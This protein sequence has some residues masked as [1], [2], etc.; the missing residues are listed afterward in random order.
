MILK[1][2]GMKVDHLQFFVFVSKIQEIKDSI[3]KFSAS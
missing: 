2:N 1:R 3:R